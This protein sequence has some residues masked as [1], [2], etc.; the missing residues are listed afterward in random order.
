MSFVKSICN[1]TV[2]SFLTTHDDSNGIEV[3]DINELMQNDMSLQVEQILFQNNAEIKAEDSNFTASS[4][5]CSSDKNQMPSS[6]SSIDINSSSSS[7]NTNM[8]NSN[9]IADF[10]IIKSPKKKKVTKRKEKTSSIC[11]SFTKSYLNS[12]K[13]KTD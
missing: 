5:S 1:N 2:Y 3:E 10:R 11:V 12:S 7:I 4:N 9:T 13:I 8:H 6:V